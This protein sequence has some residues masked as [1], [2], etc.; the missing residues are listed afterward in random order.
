MRAPM[1][2]RIRPPRSRCAGVKSVIA[3]SLRADLTV[4]VVALIS[5]PFTRRAIDTG[6]GPPVGSADN[7]ENTAVIAASRSHVEVEMPGHTS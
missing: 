3:H 1:A 4:Q 2:R 6:L 5:W 7:C